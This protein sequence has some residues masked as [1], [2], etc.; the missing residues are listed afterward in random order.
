MQSIAFPALGRDSL[1]YPPEKVAWSML[2]SVIE[3]FRDHPDPF[4]C[5]LKRVFIVADGSDLNIKSVSVYA[6]WVHLQADLLLC[7]TNL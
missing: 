7:T 3:Y 2:M 5:S 6:P 4:T 1:N